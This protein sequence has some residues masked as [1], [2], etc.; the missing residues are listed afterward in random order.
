MADIQLTNGDDTYTQP[1]ANRTVFDNYYGNDGN[2]TLR[3]YS[4][5]VLGGRGNDRIERL[6]YPNE[7]WRYAA[8]AYWNSPKG[9]RVDLTEGWAEDGYGTRDTLI[10]FD[11]AIGSN[12]DD[13]LRGNANDNSLTTNGG[14]DTVIGG[15][16]TDTVYP[17]YQSVDV[18]RLPL[19][20][21]IRIQVSLDGN[22]AVI[23]PLVGKPFKVTTTE[24][25]RVGVW[26]GTY[27]ANGN[28]LTVTHPLLDFITPQQMAEQAVAAG[29]ALRWNAS[30]PLGTPASLSYSFVTQGPAS[31]PGASGFRAFTEAEKAAVRSILGSTWALTGLNF[32][33]VAEAGG[34]V[35]QMRFGVSSQAATKGLSWLPNQPGAGDNAGDVWMDI[36]SMAN[37]AP[38]TEGW[39]A[40]LHEIG[41]ALGLRHPRNVDAGDTWAEQLRAPD[42][43]TA[44]TVM[45]GNASSDGLFR[46][47]WGPLDVLALRHLYGTRSTNTGDTVYALNATHANT[48]T[49]VQ[50]DGGIDTL[51]ASAL[52]VGAVLD[53]RPGQVSSVGLSA[54][55]VAGVENLGLTASSWIEHAIGTDWDDVI[56][57]NDLANRL[58]GGTGNDR[59]DG[60]KGID[61]ALFPGARGAYT[62]A[63]A[64]TQSTVK[65]NDGQGGF[66]TLL[67]V[68]R[69]QFADTRVALD[70]DGAAGTVA[71][72]IRAVF[73]PQFLSTREFVGIGLDYADRGWTAAAL[74]DLAM[75][76]PLVGELAGSR[77]NLDVVKLLYRNVAG[78]TPGAAEAAP[79]VAMLD[80]GSHTQASLALLAAQHPGNT[81]SPELMG[82][83]TSGI[84]FLPVPG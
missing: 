64:A 62:V 33:E 35:G 16:G 23:E 36:E 79:F 25:E 24:V 37:L 28:R 55:G 68:E 48:E 59:I 66:D 57:G 44:L 67:A 18:F 39:Q 7:A 14:T 26:S 71:G 27:E 15:A 47:D 76:I 54:A 42:D 51:D 32:T 77:N 6:I 10:G 49:A 61:T 9:V 83:Q 30:A 50:D 82:L 80:S 70:L 40:L 73:G 45:S 41:H 31:G 75:S 74:V 52:T 84:E 29:G 20:S 63:R 56:T 19:L 60:G 1:E 22:T 4:G 58:T 81:G 3:V 53:L 5:T 2:D 17:W 43:R 21:E 11:H 72:V 13:W 8:V 34:T 65:A 69:L 12:G 38:G 78:V 46:S